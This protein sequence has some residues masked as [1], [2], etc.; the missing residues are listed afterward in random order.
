[1]ARSRRRVA[2]G[3]AAWH[4]PPASST[5][6]RVQRPISHAPPP[7][8][9]RRDGEPRRR[10]RGGHHG[11]PPPAPARLHPG[12]G[13]AAHAQRQLV[14]CEPGRGPRRPPS[15]A[16]AAPGRAAALQSVEAGP[17]RAFARGFC[18]GG[19]PAGSSSAGAGACLACLA[20]AAAD[21]SRGCGN[22]SRRA[23]VWRSGCFLAYADTGA[24][25]AHED[26]FRGWFYAG[27]KTAGALAGGVCVGYRVP[28]DCTRCLYDSL[29]AAPA[30]GW[31]SRLRGDEV[32][33]AGYSCCLRVQKP[34][35]EQH[36]LPELIQ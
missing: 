26:A 17:D 34:P 30:L 12:A 5:P 23:G 9:R 35:Y 21:V 20:A 16:A 2:V 25:S 27:P 4:K 32:I 11:R 36:Q 31:L 28:A 3:G 29:R 14:P 7:R 1:M 33:V 13:A 15:I 24:A 6:P 10:S 22:A 8:R 19:P 18:F